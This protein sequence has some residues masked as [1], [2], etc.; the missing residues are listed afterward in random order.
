[1]ATDNCQTARTQPAHVQYARKSSFRATCQ[2]N[3]RGVAAAGTICIFNCSP[4]AMA[5]IAAYNKDYVKAVRGHGVASAAR[6][7]A[8]TIATRFALSNCQWVALAQA[9]GRC[10]DNRFSSGCREGT[11]VQIRQHTPPGIES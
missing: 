11:A 6:E 7:D 3:P 4:R 9:E 1:M 8:T 10:L 5:R 2:D